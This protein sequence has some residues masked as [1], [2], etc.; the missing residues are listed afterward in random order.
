M[1]RYTWILTRD[2]FIGNSSDAVGKLGPPGAADRE[3]FDTVII[4]G[5]HF[6]MLNRKGEPRYSGYI[7]G[8]FGGAEPLDEYGA[9][10]GCVHIE[11]ERDGQW[12][13][14]ESFKDSRTSCALDTTDPG[15]D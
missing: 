10:N 5:E 7:I 14:L 11:F 13:S 12:M 6:R 4:H 9:E 15:N 8:E 2:S 1:S 3:R